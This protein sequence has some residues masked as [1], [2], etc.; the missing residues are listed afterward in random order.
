MDKEREQARLCGGC[1]SVELPQVGRGAGARGFAVLLIVGA[2]LVSLFAVGTLWWERGGREWIG[3][4][5]GGS[6]SREESDTTNRETPPLTPPV[7]P[8]NPSDTMPPVT[9]PEGAIPIVDRDLAESSLGRNYLHN[10]T[11]YSPDVGQLLQLPLEELPLTDAPLVLILHTHT[12]EA[13]L[14]QGSLYVEGQ[15]G[16]AVYSKDPARGVT[17]VGRVL[18][19]T[20]NA[21][22]IPTVHCT[23]AHDQPLMSGAYQRSYETVRRY[24]ALYPSIRLVIDLHRDSILD[25]DG[26]YIR[27]V[28]EGAE[29]AVAQVMAVVGSDGNG[30]PHPHWEENLSLAL[31]LRERLNEKQDGVCRPVSLRN[32]SYHQELSRYSLLLEIGSGANSLE[33]AKRAAILVGECLAE[34]IQS[35]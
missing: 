14:P 5:W 25:A 10:E 24:L 12:G 29:D 30:T 34:L 16:D 35:R 1:E 9:L 4:H 11:S 32:A 13:Y 6:A 33:E 20:L 21:H 23:V 22:G 26:A 28:T 7:T 17:E 18:C 27:T 31:R 3:N 19:E 15:L 2:L 8:N